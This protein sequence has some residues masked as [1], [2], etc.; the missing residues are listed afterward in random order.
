MD[1]PP[2]P[3]SVHKHT[4]LKV[5]GG[6]PSTP[7]VSGQV[8]CLPGTHSWGLWPGDMYVL[9]THQR[10]L[11]MCHMS[12]WYVVLPYVCAGCLS[13]QQALH[14]NKLYLGFSIKPQLPSSVYWWSVTYANGFWYCSESEA[15]QEFGVRKVHIAIIS[16]VYMLIGSLHVS[17]Y[18]FVT[19]NCIL[20]HFGWFDVYTGPWV[21]LYSRTFGL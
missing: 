16:S 17:T 21:I 11:G 13:V 20:D 14:I 6:F 10:A 7:K 19:Y 2:P 4:P 5:L 1:G 18:I 12:S 9:H 15:S 8:V 3:P